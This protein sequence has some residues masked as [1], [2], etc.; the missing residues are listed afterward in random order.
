MKKI[1]I[2]IL[3]TLFSTFIFA[4]EFNFF[5]VKM[6]VTKEEAETLLLE[7]GFIKG[8]AEVGELDVFD[9]IFFKNTAN[10]IQVTYKPSATITY[11]GEEVS[12]ITVNYIQFDDSKNHLYHLIFPKDY[13]LYHIHV[14]F[15]NEH[16]LNIMLIIEAIRNKY[17]TW[18]QETSIYNSNDTI[19]INNTVIIEKKF[20]NICEILEAEK[21]KS[22][23]VEDDI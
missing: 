5:G 4:D 23:N 17:K 8:D 18:E 19:R 3:L 2:G 11:G 15:K 14:T 12:F 10:L 6:G 22:F 9:P 20:Y 7:K 21:K 16:P 1:F 13:Y